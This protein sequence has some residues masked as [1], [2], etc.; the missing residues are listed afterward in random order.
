VICVYGKI[1]GLCTLDWVLSKF[2]LLRFS[3]AFLAYKYYCD[4]PASHPPRKEI[5]GWNLASH[6]GLQRSH[7]VL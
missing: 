6:F 4:N 5:S 7:F 2:C 3:M 1:R